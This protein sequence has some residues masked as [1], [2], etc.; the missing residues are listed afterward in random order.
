MPITAGSSGGLA[1]MTLK[2]WGHCIGGA[3]PSLIKGLNVASVT[4]SGTATRVTFTTAM[5]SANHI[6]RVF[7]GQEA[8]AP[9]VGPYSQAAGS[10]DIVGY[11]TTGTTNT[12]NRF[13]F[14]VWE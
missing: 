9:I 12:L 2:A 14:E 1:G 11:T 13:Y 5:S 7:G 3:S 6:V 10:V 8:V 4:V